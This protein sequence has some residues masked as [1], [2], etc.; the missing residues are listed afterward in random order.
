MAASD[1]SQSRPA[2]PAYPAAVSERATLW[3]LIAIVA[4]VQFPLGSNRPWSWSLLVLLVAL[5]WLC[6]IPAGVADLPMTAR[7]ARRVALPGL[8]LLAV[9]IWVWI[10]SVGF[11]PST[12][13]NPVWRIA[14]RGLGRPVAGAISINPFATTTEW[15]K[16]ASYVALGWLAGV[17]AARHGNA[18]TLFVAVFAVGVFYAAYGIVLSALGTSQITLFESL[19]PPYG[20]DV[21]GGFVAKNSFATFTGVAL[22]AGLALLVKA[23]RHE[24]VVARGWRTHLRTL[25]QYALGRG[26]VWLV[27]SLILLAALIASDSR[28]GLLAAFSGLFVLFGLALTVSARRDEMKW[29]AIGGAGAVVAI[30][31]LFLVNGHTLQSRFENLIDTAGAGELRP[32][33]WGTALRALADHPLMGTGL[34][35]YRDAY[36]L[37]ADS[38]VPFV[39]DRAHNDYLEFAMGVGIPAASLWILALA[40]LTV[41]CALGAL[42]RHRRRLYAMTA[43]GATVL[44]GVHSMFDFSLQM[45]AVSVLY[46][47]IMGVGIGQ[48]QS[49][50]DTAQGAPPSSF[51]VP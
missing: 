18:R 10:Q 20:R 8:L 35:T 51:V 45:P 30:L 12:W 25:I 49:S 50:R 42:R 23:G 19:P 40:M 7:S 47:V 32:A 27:G 26:A 16:L 43:V 41:Q 4:W 21:S 24:I 31:T 2:S 9:L 5:D 39:V 37:Y 48:S 13:H 1:M 36:P 11:T 22:L 38:F 33:L 14:G 34:G 28:A 15:M 46:A 3:L 44:V 6:W 29:T 17:L